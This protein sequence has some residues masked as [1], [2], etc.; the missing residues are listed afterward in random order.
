[1]IKTVLNTWISRSISDTYHSYSEAR[2]A[3]S[4]LGERIACAQHAR[5]ALTIVFRMESRNPSVKRILSRY[6]NGFNRYIRK[7]FKPVE[8]EPEAF[9]ND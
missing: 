7:W 6:F 1:L 4:C 3:I 5:R 2:A 8:T 9:L